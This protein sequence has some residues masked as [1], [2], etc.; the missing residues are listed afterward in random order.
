M[1][2]KTLRERA[3]ET[4]LRIWPGLKSSPWIRPNVEA[5]Y[6]A[7]HRAN[8]L[9]AKERAVVEAAAAWRAFEKAPHRHSSDP[10]YSA[11]ASERIALSHALDAALSNLDQKAREHG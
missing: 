9:T 8:R 6:L 3:W 4:A 10:K 2:R 11:W 5:I 7:G 1:P